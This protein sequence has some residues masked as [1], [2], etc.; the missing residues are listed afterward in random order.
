[1][2]RSAKQGSEARAR[3]EPG[4]AQP[5]DRPVTADE[6]RFATANERVVLDLSLGSGR[7]VNPRLALS[8]VTARCAMFQIRFETGEIFRT[9]LSAPRQGRSLADTARN[10]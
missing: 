10:K 1:M 9:H 8:H 3:I 6:R 5:I 7:A 2:L 4:P